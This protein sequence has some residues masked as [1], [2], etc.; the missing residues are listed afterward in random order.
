MKEKKMEIVEILNKINQLNQYTEAYN[1]GQP[2]ISDAEWDNLYFELQNVEK[3]TGI[4][5]P[6]SP[7]QSINYKMVTNLEKVRHNKDFPMLSLDKTK[8]LTDVEVKFK[9]K[10][11]IAMPKC[12]GLSCRLIYQNGQLIQA[13]TRGNGLVGEDITH[14]AFAVHNIPITIPHDGYLVVDGEIVCFDNDFLTFAQDYS[15]SRNFAAGSIRLLDSA[16]VAKRK[17]SFIAWDCIEDSDSESSLLSQQL[18]E[19]ILYGFTIVDYCFSGIMEIQKVVEYLKGKAKEN[20][21]PIDGIVFKLDDKVEYYAAGTTAHHPLGAYAFK[22]YD[23]EY[24][25][26]LIDIEYETSKQGILT[27]V[28]IYKPVDIDGAICSKCTLHNLSVMQEV[29]GEYPI[30]GQ[31]IWVYR[32]NQVTP[33][34]ARAEKIASLNSDFETLLPPSQC[35]TCG[36]PT[37]KRISDSGVVELHCNN[38]VC[39]GK[40]IN[41][42]DHFCSKKGLDIKGL[43]KATLEK[44][45]DWGWVINIVDLFK[46]SAHRSE[47]IQKPEFGE[48]SVDKI[49]TAIDSARYPTFEQF[50]SAISIPLI[51]KTYA[52]KIA[53]VYDDYKSFRTAV[54]QGKDFSTIDGFGSERHEAIVKFDYREADNLL[55]GG[56]L[57]IV[58]EESGMENSGNALN[59]KTFCVTG[60]VH[61]WKNREELATAISAVGGKV[62]SSVSAK[63]DYLINNEINSTSSK[64][65]KAKELNIPIITEEQ[66]L[67][68]MQ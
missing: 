61:I 11:W 59:G 22:F 7:T 50:L 23:E 44:L 51:G 63:T 35:P 67:E 60:K 16:E 26:E 41:R 13:S 4:I 57:E 20:G 9:N 1:R 53:S 40:L 54:V 46:L 5:F 34:I 52:K 38:D 45:I 19:L 32:A 25:T 17:L 14:S 49:L 37:E 33:Q 18:E 47:W 12:D 10:E 8:N 21:L 3:Q 29:L 15:N 39:E 55:Y 31:K 36:A 42:L 30:K 64:N 48:K 24:E 68:I 6:N 43:S 56:Y 66:L 58:K 62:T 27:P 2:L 28:A 65:I